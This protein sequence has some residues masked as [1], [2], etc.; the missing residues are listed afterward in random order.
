M[1][2][3]NKQTICFKVIETDSLSVNCFEGRCHVQNEL[4]TARTK[5][6]L[7]Q[8]ARELF[9]RDGYAQTGTEAIIAAAV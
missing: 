1:S 6:R 5:G 3:R 9:A 7:V 2:I 8:V 4:R